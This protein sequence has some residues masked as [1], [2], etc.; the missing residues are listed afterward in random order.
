MLVK[1]CCCYLIT[2]S[3][4]KSISSKC[5]AFSQRQ[6][7]DLMLI[8]NATVLALPLRLALALNQTACVMLKD[9]M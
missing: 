8:N 5:S 3:T 9:I 2:T 6:F 4:T 7:N 1:S